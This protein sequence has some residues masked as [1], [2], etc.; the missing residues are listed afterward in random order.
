VL[1]PLVFNIA[2]MICALIWTA[3][4]HDKILPILEAYADRFPGSLVEEKEF[5]VVWHYRN[6]D[7]EQGRLG[8]M[9]LTDDLHRFTANIDLQVLQGHKIIEVRNAGINK[10]M[11]VAHWLSKG[12]FGFVMGI[13][14]DATDEDLFAALPA[15]AYSIRVGIGRTQARLNL[16]GPKEVISLLGYLVREDEG[17]AA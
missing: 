11:A 5:S 2:A 6:I 8:S 14:D 12:K 10:G 9:E 1:Y 16:R 17:T 7:P 4:I 15:D 13:G 3:V